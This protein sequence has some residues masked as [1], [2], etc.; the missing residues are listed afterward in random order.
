LGLFLLHYKKL[1]HK[2]L[3]LFLYQEKNGYLFN[4]D[5][6]FLYDFITNFNPKGEV[7]DIGCGCGIL[8]LLTARDFKV[9]LT[10]IDKQ[11]HNIFLT[12][13]NAE[14]N[15]LQTDAKKEDFLTHVFDKQFDF[16]ISNPP[17]YH[18][19]VSKS[20]NKAL[21]ISRYSE[22]LPIEKFIQKVKSLLKHRG[23]FIFCYDAGSLQELM[24]KLK[25]AKLTVEDIRFVHGTSLKNSSLVMIHARNSS[26]AKTKIHPPL[27][28]MDKDDPTQEVKSI[29]QKTRTYSIKCTI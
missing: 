16:I 15:T 17:Y 10:S 27:V 24:V 28:N 8:G 19:G 7:L 5:T 3:W 20:E 26:L 21:H 1:I 6:H 22:H 11:E 9:S 2:A 12:L 13:K 29:Y 14:I 4:S 23:H 25:E 18:D